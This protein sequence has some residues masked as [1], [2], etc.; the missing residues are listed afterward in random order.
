MPVGSF[1]AG[2]VAEAVGEPTT[3]VISASI[4]LVFAGLVFWRTKIRE[5]K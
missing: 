4:L 2:N 3:A 5:I 1:L